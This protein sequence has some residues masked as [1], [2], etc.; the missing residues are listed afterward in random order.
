MASRESPAGKSCC[1]TEAAGHC[2]TPRDLGPSVLHVG[3]AHIPLGIIPVHSNLF[4]ARPG[5]LRPLPGHLRSA[6]Q[7]FNCLSRSHQHF[8]LWPPVSWAQSFGPNCRRPCQVN[9]EE[10]QGHVRTRN[11]PGLLPIMVGL[12]H[13]HHRRLLHLGWE[14]FNQDPWPVPVLCLVMI[15]L[16]AQLGE[17]GPCTSATRQSVGLRQVQ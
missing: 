15:N 16:G 4:I 1:L 8:S 7:L 5:I 13:L 3:I 14:L 11:P 17:Y 12:H 9:G 6:L 2:A 10:R